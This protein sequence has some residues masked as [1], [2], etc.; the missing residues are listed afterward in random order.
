MINGSGAAGIAVAKLLLRYG[1]PDVILC[2]RNGM[3]SSR[4]PR[5][6]WIKKEMLK[7]TNLE[8]KSGTLADALKG[9]GIF[10]GVS[11]AVKGCVERGRMKKQ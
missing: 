11:A 4:S 1:F 3:I 9:A 10:I 5:L 6:N 8:D 7:T 2:D